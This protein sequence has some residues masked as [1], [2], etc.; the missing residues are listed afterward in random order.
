M[1]HIFYVFTT[2]QEYIWTEC[3]SILELQ[4]NWYKFQAEVHE[5][6]QFDFCTKG[7]HAKIALQYRS[8]KSNSCF[9][10]ILAAI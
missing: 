9:I 10:I 6:M 2:H 7:S 8:W 3:T 5:I 1:Y 4:N